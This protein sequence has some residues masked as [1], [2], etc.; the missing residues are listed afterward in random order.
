MRSPSGL[1]NPQAIFAICLPDPAPTEHGTP[2]SRRT[3]SRS[4]LANSSTATSSAPD[5]A[6]GS[7]NSSSNATCSSGPTISRTTLTTR[8][9]TA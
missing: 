9:L 7:V 8:S 3:R 4:R 5:S 6:A 1:A 2:V